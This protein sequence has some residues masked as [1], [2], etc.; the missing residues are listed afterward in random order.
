VPL[1]VLSFFDA[2]FGT[3]G[4][5]NGPDLRMALQQKIDG[6]RSTDPATYAIDI[7]AGDKLLN[8][9]VMAMLQVRNRCSAV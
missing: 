2:L 9:T 6:I 1:I 4:T 5:S 8:S 3:T 7:A